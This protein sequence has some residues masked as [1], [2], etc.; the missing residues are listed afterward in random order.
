[1][2]EMSTPEGL[3]QSNP[4][5][6]LVVPAFIPVTQQIRKTTH[7]LCVPIF[8]GTWLSSPHS[9]GPSQGTVRCPGP[10][11]FHDFMLTRLLSHTTQLC[12]FPTITMRQ[13]AENLLPPAFRWEDLHKLFPK[14]FSPHRIYLLSIYP[15][16]QLLKACRQAAFVKL[17]Q[18]APN[19]PWLRLFREPHVSLPFQQ[20]QTEGT[21]P[22]GVA[23]KQ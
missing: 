12:T 3:G 1:M 5:A 15:G 9:L 20:M 23:A 17:V 10:S 11:R 19:N 6:D 18:E 7:S 16:I 21:K 13:T 2:L 14:V 4:I 22:G 8:P